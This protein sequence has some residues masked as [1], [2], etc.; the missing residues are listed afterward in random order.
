M[1]DP[2]TGKKYMVLDTPTLNH[3]INQQTCRNI[4]GHLPEPRDE[5]ENL[6]LDS[7]ASEMFLLGINDSQVEGQWVYASDGS[8]V[9]WKSWVNWRDYPDSPRVDRGQNCAGMLRHHN[10]QHVG[11]RSQ[12]WFNLPCPSSNYFESKPKSLICEKGR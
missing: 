10:K 7:L 8:L 12:D 6:F 3:D 4:G 5:Q 2:R 11:H 1:S 9:V